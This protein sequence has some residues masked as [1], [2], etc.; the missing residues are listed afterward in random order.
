M[1]YN[2][3]VF[4]IASENK[5]YHQIANWDNSYLVS[6]EIEYGFKNKIPLRLFG[7]L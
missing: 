7:F 6:D 3:Y 2:N 5:T 4:E 1:V